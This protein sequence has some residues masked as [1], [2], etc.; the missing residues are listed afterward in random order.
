MKTVNIYEQGE[1]VMIKAR[2]ADI[3]I[4]NGKLRYT[5]KDEK[6]NKTYGWTFADSDIIP[7]NEEQTDEK[8]DNA[9]GICTDVDRKAGNDNV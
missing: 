5:L 3:A 4:E 2:V 1:Q 8:T 7:I 6:A 9:G